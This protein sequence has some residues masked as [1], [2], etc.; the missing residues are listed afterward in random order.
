MEYQHFG[1]YGIV[2]KDASI[3]L[4]RKHGG[5]YD[6]MLDLPGGTIEFGETFEDALKREFKEEVGLEILDMQL[7]HVDSV[8]FDW[9][10]KGK[11][12]SVHHLGVFYFV[13]NY[14]GD[15]LEKI[16]IDVTNDDSLG[17]R[18]YEIKKLNDQKLSNIA[19]LVIKKV[20]LLNGESK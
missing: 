4:I 15:I 11:I 17:A 6:G 3:L 18:F 9:N 19:R 12:I 10:Y 13:L 14:Q 2:I 5:P 20:M 7:F 16:N 1:M 8:L